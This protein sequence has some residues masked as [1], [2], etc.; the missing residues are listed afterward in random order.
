[1][2]FTDEVSQFA[3][4]N[5]Q[6]EFKE[7]LRENKIKS[8]LYYIFFLFEEE[9]RDV[10]AIVNCFSSD[11]FEILYPWGSSN[12]KEELVKWVSNIDEKSEYAH[13]IQNIEIRF[14]DNQKSEVK[15]DLTYQTLNIDKE[16]KNIKLHYK[17]ELIETKERYPKIKKYATIIVK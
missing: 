14:I 6:M 1:M 4:D 7:S 12:S 9:K 15:V 17:F 10:D 2:A 16:L 8:F 11:G 5:I 3:Q 13:H